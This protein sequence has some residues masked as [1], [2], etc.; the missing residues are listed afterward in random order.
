MTPLR[1]GRDACRSRLP[2]SPIYIGSVS[3]SQQEAPARLIYPR[4]SDPRWVQFACLAAFLAVYAW[5]APGFRREPAQVLASFVSCLGL[6]VLLLVFYRRLPLVPFSGFLCSVWTVVLIESPAPWVYAAAGALATAAKH[7]LRVD[8]KHLFVPNNF[9]AVAALLL[10]PG[11]A[12]LISAPWHG[13]SPALLAAAAL[14]LIAA[15]AAGRLAVPAAYLAT[16]AAGALAR[17]WWGQEDVWRP[18][19]AAA[20]PALHLFAFFHLSDPKATPERRDGQLA[21]GAAVGAADALLRAAGAPHAPFLALF[22]V[23][24]SLPLFRRRFARAQEERSWHL[25]LAPLPPAVAPWFRPGPN[26]R[27]AGSAARSLAVAFAAASALAA[28]SWARRPESTPAQRGERLARRAGCFACHGPGGAGGVPNPGS[29]AGF[30]PGFDGRTLQA[31]ALSVAELTEWIRDGRPR[32][33]AGERGDAGLLVMPAY[34]ERFSAR[35]LEELTAF[36]AAVSGL[37]PGMPEAA[38][39]GRVVAERLGCFGCHG[40]SGMGGLENPGSLSGRIP[41]WTGPDYAELARDEG[42]FRAWVLD[43]GIPRL[44]GN[45]AARWFLGRQA[46]KMPAYRA[47]ISEDELDKLAA[48]LR[49]LRG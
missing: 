13:P 17:A 43:G 44:R 41:A 23:A 48:Y 40:P 47:R 10:A 18:L 38:Y 30:V 1:I 29:A 4:L 16:F 5:L 3:L 20:G 36:V 11:A 46:V 37:D 21:Y 27:R 25:G 33:L 26:P 31:Y 42:E 34:A 45:P 22:V 8:G 6:D 14:G 12:G 9:G 32:R 28:L 7:F 19:S 49:R 15:R 2:R 39:E 24:W 35:E